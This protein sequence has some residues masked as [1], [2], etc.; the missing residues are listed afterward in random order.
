MQAVQPEARGQGGWCRLGVLLV[1]QRAALGLQR[2]VQ[3]GG[4]Q[5]GDQ[6][7]VQRDPLRAEV[8]A[9][10]FRWELQP[11]VQAGRLRS[12]V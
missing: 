3:V 5:Q 6:P 7:E 2:E 1:R 12:E 11:V 10:N 9:G 8:Q 4:F